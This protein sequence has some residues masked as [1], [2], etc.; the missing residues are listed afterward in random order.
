MFPFFAIS[1][2]L[3]LIYRLVKKIGMF[4]AIWY[5]VLFCECVLIFS[6]FF[7]AYADCNHDDKNLDLILVVDCA[8]SNPVLLRRLKTQLRHLIN[9]IFDSFHLR[10]ALISYQN[11][12]RL[13][14]PGMRSGDPQ[15]NNTALIQKFTDK[16][17]TMKETIES[18]RCLGRPGGTRG[19]A[20]GLAL[21]V[22]LSEVG[23]DSNN[24]KCR[25]NAIKVCILL[26]EYK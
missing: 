2:Y 4:C 16:R 14:R 18:L 6:V 12:Q 10:L 23:G 26:R 11:H 13:P 19:L 5:T 20:D 8:L 1:S 9:D 17:D 25:K 3:Q 24:L 7:A 21:A 22:Q 15:I